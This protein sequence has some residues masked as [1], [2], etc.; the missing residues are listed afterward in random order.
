L[1]IETE[2][3]STIKRGI[4]GKQLSPRTVRIGKTEEK[5]S[6]RG[7]EEFLGIDRLDVGGHRLV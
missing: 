6:R 7:S 3:D 1:T 4:S 5:E 2:T